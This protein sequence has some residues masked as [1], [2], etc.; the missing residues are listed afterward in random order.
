MRCSDNAMKENYINNSISF[1]SQPD[2]FL[3]FYAGGG[4]FIIV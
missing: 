4:I 1:R 3:C 2:N